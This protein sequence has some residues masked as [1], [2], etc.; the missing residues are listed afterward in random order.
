[1]AL[2]VFG[3][4]TSTSHHVFGSAGSNFSRYHLV[5]RDQGCL[6]RNDPGGRLGPIA[7]VARAHP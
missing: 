6:G 2:A 5:L 4:P 7:Q 3:P 1:M